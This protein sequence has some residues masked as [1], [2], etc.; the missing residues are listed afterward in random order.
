M[1]STTT[2]TTQ[3]SP[4]LSTFRLI[5]YERVPFTPV[6]ECDRLDDGR[7]VSPSESH[8]LPFS[9][10]VGVSPSQECLRHPFGTAWCAAL[11]MR[12][13]LH[14]GQSGANGRSGSL[15]RGGGVSPA[16]SQLRKSVPIS[17]VGIGWASVSTPL[18]VIPPAQLV[19]NRVKGLFR[20][21]FCPVV[22][23]PPPE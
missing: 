14:S 6:Y 12:T 18:S 15:G 5:T 19:P 20:A 7:M 21:R 1:N 2:V 9:V 22:E 4:T 11:G 23:P 13:L 17:T 3:L 10:Y 16:V 8:S